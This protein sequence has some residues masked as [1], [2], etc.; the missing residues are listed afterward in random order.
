MKRKNNKVIIEKKDVENKK[1]KNEII[2]YEG[3]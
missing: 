3:K 1:I 2:K